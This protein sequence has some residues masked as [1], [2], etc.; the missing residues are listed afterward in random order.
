MP[1]EGKSI[2]EKVEIIYHLQLY[3]RLPPSTATIIATTR[4]CRTFQAHM[5][6]CS[7]TY[8]YPNGIP[9]QHILI[10]FQVRVHVSVL[11]Q[12]VP[13]DNFQIRDWRRN[14][15]SDRWRT[16]QKEGG[17]HIANLPFRSRGLCGGGDGEKCDCA[18]LSS[19]GTKDGN[20]FHA[21]AK[22]RMRGK[23]EGER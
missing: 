2:K 15:N 20:A 1:V 6:R 8:S 21:D 14:P 19:M 23:R 9:S 22:W 12:R 13:L 3:L 11:T 18:G 4:S 17:L 5:L 7:T 16:K 10:K